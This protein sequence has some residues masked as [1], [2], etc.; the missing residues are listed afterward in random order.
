LD[1]LSESQPFMQGSENMADSSLKR[2]V[3]PLDE[4]RLRV[5]DDHGPQVAD[6]IKDLKP[7]EPVSS[8]PRILA[9]PDREHFKLDWNESTIPPSPNVRKAVMQYLDSQVSLNYYPQLFSPDLRLRLQSH[10]GYPKDHILITNGS[11]DALELICKTYLNPGDRVLSPYPT[12]THALLFAKSRGAIIDKVVFEDTFAGTLDEILD[13]ITERTKIIYLVNPNNPTGQLFSEEDLARIAEAAPQAVV[14]IDEAYHEFSHQTVIGLVGRYRNV[15]VTR[16]F[17]KLWGLAAVRIG[18]M[19]A[20]PPIIT[21]LCRLYNPKSVNQIAQVAALAALEDREYYEKYLEEVDASK[22][23]F[24]RWC[25]KRGVDFHNTSANYVLI[26]VE[27]VKEVVEA[28]AEE[29]VYVRDRSS[30]PRL[31]GYFRLNLGT[32]DQ[33][34]EVLRRFEKVLTRF[35]II[36]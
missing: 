36:S 17:S 25:L 28:L 5:L 7:Y 3:L 30:F 34:K 22:Q 10:V 1:V 18:Y 2:K 13:A 33:T 6:S 4:A 32:V 8:L 31:A 26:H 12:Y 16:T 23:L 24:E 19:V 9:D 20:Q 35:G 15:I 21:H 14:L 11:D 29:G 27:Q